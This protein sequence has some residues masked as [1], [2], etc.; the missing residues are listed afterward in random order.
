MYFVQFM[1]FFLDLFLVDQ[2]CWW[3]YYTKLERDHVDHRDIYFRHIKMCV[4]SN[5][6]YNRGAGSHICT[7]NIY[8][9]RT[10]S[11]EIVFFIF[12]WINKFCIN[13][14]NLGLF[15]FNNQFPWLKIWYNLAR[16]LIC[17][18]ATDLLPFPATL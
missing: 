11:H 8:Y 14:I 5:L 15:E 13:Y 12:I 4:E 2:Y 9:S 16:V 17:W 7:W 18:I 3:V 10:K 6:T 1:R